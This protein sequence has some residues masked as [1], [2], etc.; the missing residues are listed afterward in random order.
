M[1]LPIDGTCDAM[2]LMCSDVFSGCAEQHNSP[3]LFIYFSCFKRLWT[4]LFVINALQYFL[5]N[6]ISIYSSLSCFLHYCCTTIDKKI[7]NMQTIYWNRY[8]CSSEKWGVE[9]A[10]SKKLFRIKAIRNHPQMASFLIDLNTI[11]R[12]SRIQRTWAITINVNDVLIET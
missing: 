10:V 6:W 3:V 9:S 12:F 7:R 4:F 5:F 2:F 8:C 11:S 1:A